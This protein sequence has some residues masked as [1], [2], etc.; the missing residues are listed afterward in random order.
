M[1]LG[2]RPVSAAPKETVVEVAQ[3]TPVYPLLRQRR[4]KSAKQSTPPHYN[5]EDF[6]S[7]MLHHHKRDT[8]RVYAG[9]NHPEVPVPPVE[10]APALQPKTVRAKR[11]S[12]PDQL[13]EEVRQTQT[14][15]ESISHS[16]T[17]LAMR[18]ELDTKRKEVESL[19][20]A[21]QHSRTEHKSGLGSTLKRTK[22]S[23]IT[24]SAEP[25]QLMK[26]VQFLENK[27][28]ETLSELKKLQFD[29]KTIKVNEMNTA[30]E[31][32][33]AEI[34]RLQSAKSPQRRSVTDAAR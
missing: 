24:N 3:K 30:L 26:R 4:P 34:Q 28:C 7:N 12:L 6:I 21:L 22:A 5:K 2:Q 27:L 16:F 17:L 25:E 8:T 18:K 32:A 23:D 33:L 14:R 20:L 13:R 1:Y 29:K 19:R 9:A 10:E 31:A 15:E 11:H